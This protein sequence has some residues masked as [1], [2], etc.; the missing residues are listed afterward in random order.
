MYGVFILW[1]F[2]C[3]FNNLY[4]LLAM[5]YVMNWVE[6][7]AI[8]TNDAKVVFKFFKTNIFTRFGI[9]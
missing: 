9:P 8:P 4:I 6:A 3:S 5:D 1:S 7:M 2:V